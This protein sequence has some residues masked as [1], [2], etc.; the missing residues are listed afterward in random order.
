M[1]IKIPDGLPAKK[2]LIE[3]RVSVMDESTAVR[4][5]IRPLRIALLNLMPDKI[6]TETQIAR[7]LGASPLQI[8]LT[9]LRTNSYMGK[10]TPESHLLGFYKTL[11][12]VR[13]HFYD[14]IIITGAPVEN[15]PYED[16]DYWPELTEIFDWAKTA[17]YSQ[18]FICWAAQAGLYHFHN[19]QKDQLDRKRFG[20]FAHK[21]LNFSHPLTRGFDDIVHIPVS[22]YTEINKNA[23]DSR[24]ALLTLLESPE[25]GVALTVDDANRQVFMFNHL[26]YDRQTLADE[27]T[28]D[29]SRGLD[30]DLPKNYFT[31]DD[32][33]GIPVMTWRAHRNLLFSN[34]IN[35][36]YQGT[37]YDLN[38]LKDP[39]KIENWN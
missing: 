1:P 4:Q 6:V 28:R 25:S 30:T 15:L 32:P 7:V 21:R 35:M 5:D 37:P 26:E 18:F 9:L 2:I 16:V 11:D 34:W 24:S 10:N 17:C 23:I 12:D 38:D 33:S 19:I 20:V 31:N 36:V 39:Q 13:T 27:Y 22:R 8:E 3:E 29:Q 14:G